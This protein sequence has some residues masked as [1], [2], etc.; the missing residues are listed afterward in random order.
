MLD[1]GR[2]FAALSE[3]MKNPDLSTKA[4]RKAYRHEMRMIAVRPRRYGLWLLTG[5]F[6][7]VMSPSAL[8]INSLFGLW[9]PF[10]GGAMMLTAM[11]LLVIGVVLR[12]RYLA[13]RN[14]AQDMIRRIRE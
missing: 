7:L 13:Q 4:G 5:G 2:D 8:G 12:R 1:K 14:G 9:P 10:L 6:L 3:A 11:P